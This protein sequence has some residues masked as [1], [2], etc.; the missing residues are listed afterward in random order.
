[1]TSVFEVPQFGHVIVDSL[2]TPASHA[3]QPA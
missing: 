1:M 2:I 3:A